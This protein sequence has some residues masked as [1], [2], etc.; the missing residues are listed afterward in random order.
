MQLIDLIA[1]QES[2]HLKM[3]I[4]ETRTF[5]FQNVFVHAEKQYWAL[6]QTGPLVRKL[7]TQGLG[8][9][10]CELIFYRKHLRFAVKKFE[11]YRK[12]T[13]SLGSFLQFLKKRRFYDS[14]Y[15][16]IWVD[17]F[18]KY[19]TLSP[20]SSVVEQLFSRGAAILFAK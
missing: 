9:R 14:M 20:S 17:V 18:L 3:F 6:P 10:N 5:G 12:S 1:F 19:N 11:I 4:A 7:R 16:Q 2:K 15:R 13:T 8:L